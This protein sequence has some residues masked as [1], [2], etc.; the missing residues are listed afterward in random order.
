VSALE[1]ICWTAFAL[2]FWHF[3]GYPMVLMLLAAS[4][5]SAPIASAGGGERVA[6]VIAAFNEERVIAAK[7]ENALSL[8][9]DPGKYQVVVVADGSSD[10]TAEIAR[11][12]QDP[13]VVC[14]HE[15]ERRGKSHALNRAV[16]ASDVDVLVLSDANNFYS[17]NAL[18][19]L[20]ARLREPG[21][22]GATGA[23]KIIE[24][25]ERAA[26]GGDGLYWRYESKIKLA[27]SRLGGT[28]T[29]DGEIFAL[30]R[31]DFHPIPSSVINDDMYLTFRLVDAGKRVVYEP[32]AEAVEEASITI[33][34]DF[35]TKVRM[36]AGG[37]QSLRSEWRTVFGSGWFSLKFASHKLLRWLMPLVL[38]TLL[39]TSGLL[40]GRPVYG[41]LFLAQVL[42]YLLAALGWLLNSRNT[43]P[44]FAYV[45]F[46]FVAMNFAAAGGLWRFL[47]G[48]HS[49][50]WSKAAR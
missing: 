13:R 27:E 20:V 8:D 35:N 3:F 44:V 10:R 2:A 39:A 25:R 33:R 4:R 38:I 22:G 28:V 11:G 49:V 26:S 14:L 31:A 50:L 17:R 1:I 36:I 48:R 46:Y 30:R 9:H 32:A 15:P 40:S 16:A 29:A 34:E 37:M 47:R 45:P 24:S 42:F 12:F 19:A 6:L 18:R 41:A 7:I 21:V 23:K 5:G 43:R